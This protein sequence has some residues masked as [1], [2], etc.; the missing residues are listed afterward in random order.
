MKTLIKLITAWSDFNEQHPKASLVDFCNY[1]IIKEKKGHNHT[2]GEELSSFEL[3]I[4]SAKLIGRVAAMN[5][6]YIK[7]A[8]KDSGI[9]PEWFY[10]LNAIYKQQEAR[11]TDVI[12]FI[13]FEQSTGIDMMARIHAAGYISERND[14]NDKRA[15]LVKLTKR[16]EQLLFSLWEPTYR[17][18][19]FMFGNMPDSEK[20]LIINL[21]NNIE[22]HH[23]EFIT[24]N[25]SQILAELSKL[26][27]A[28]ETGGKGVV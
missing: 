19:Y 23:Q 17:A 18:T 5:Q 16:G 11:K 7:I 15:K 21:L 2:S 9:S 14:P 12:N 22:V 1:F 27:I 3:T 4:N 20:Q 24:M 13:L 25:R 6:V 10:V 28:V 8:L 26:D